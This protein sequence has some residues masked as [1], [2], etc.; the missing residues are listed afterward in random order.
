MTPAADA[1][2]GVLGAS[3]PVDARA[4]RAARRGPSACTLMGLA[5]AACL[6]GAAAVAVLA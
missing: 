2:P 3:E 6:L 1:E 5:S 4:A